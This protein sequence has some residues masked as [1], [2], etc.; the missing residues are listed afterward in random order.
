RGYGAR[1]VTYDR[2]T[3]DR[4]AI[5]AKIAAET[6][7]T[8]VPPFDHPWTMAGQG[9][10]AMEL[11][12]QAPGI[13][14]LVAPIGGGGLISGC[15]VAAKALNPGIRIFGVEP[16]NA[17]DTFLSLRAGQR[18]A[19]P[20]PNTSADG[21][22]A[23][24]PGELTFQIIREHVEAVLLVSE[25]EIRAAMTFLLTRMKIVVEPSGAVSAAS[26]LFRKLPA[27]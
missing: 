23:T 25:E 12:E 11:L 10:A 17:N 20:I 7:A 19:I 16:E 24:R 8:L 9:T 18:V 13:D 14:A 6:G 27:D 3:E 26:V 15:A 5:G 4:E 22:R 1:I 2:M 21:L